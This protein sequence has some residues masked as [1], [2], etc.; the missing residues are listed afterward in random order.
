MKKYL[1]IKS[2]FWP[3]RFLIVGKNAEAVQVSRHLRLFPELG[4]DLLGFIGDCDSTPDL[5]GKYLGPLDNL[6]GLVKELCVDELVIAL[7]GESRIKQF[8]LL[9]R[10]EALVPRVSVLPELFDADKL[11]VDIEKVERYFFLSFQNNLMKRSNRWLKNS[12]EILILLLFLPLWG[13][14]LLLLS[15]LTK[16]SSPGPIFFSQKR[17]GAGGH[18]FSCYKFRT[19]VV[20]ADEQLENLFRE[21]PQRLHEWETERKLKDDP[22]ITRIGRFLR[23]TS[24][25]ELPQLINVL[26]GEM[27]LIGPRPIVSEEVP[28]Y[29]DYFR[30]YKSVCPGLSGLW[31]VSGRNDV[32]YEQRVMLDTFYVRN[33][34]L[35]MDFMILLRTL[36]AVWK[37]EGAY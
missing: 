16:M 34:S 17:I 4:Y 24:L 1:L 10:S 12:F 20:D 27:S 7:P 33:W 18:V 14:A 25:D 26:R 30:Y 21:Q 28:K 9:K 3:R 2:S 6:E 5:P 35:W 23:R 8:D 36:P 29:G 22:R 13:T 37:K 32:E 31:Q 15:A 19:M 11:N